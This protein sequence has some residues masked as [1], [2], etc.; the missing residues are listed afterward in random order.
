MTRD[1]DYRADL[2]HSNVEHDF[3]SVHPRTNVTQTIRAL[4][5]TSVYS[6]VLIYHL[7]Y[8]ALILYD[9]CHGESYYLDHLAQ[10]ENEVIAM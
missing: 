9:H 3:H 5:F 2:F 4:G 8:S 7:F 6:F 1:A 10:H